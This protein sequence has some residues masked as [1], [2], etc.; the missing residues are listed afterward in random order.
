MAYA[1]VSTKKWR[2]IQTHT[3]YLTWQGA[4]LNGQI[5]LLWT[6]LLFEVQHHWDQ[7]GHFPHA[8]KKVPKN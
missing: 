2:E 3:N 6:L 1:F 7:Y 4:L 5:V 8:Q